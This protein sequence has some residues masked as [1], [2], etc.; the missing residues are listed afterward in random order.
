LTTPKTPGDQ[1]PGSSRG[2]ALAVF[3]PL[4]D[5]L[6]QSTTVELFQSR[7]IAVAP[8]SATVGNPLQPAYFSAAGVVTVTTPKGSG[9]LTLSWE[10]PVFSLF[11]PPVVATSL[12]ARDLLRELTNQLS[13]RVKNR[14][15]NFSLLL[16]IGVPSVLS[17]QALKRQRLRRDTEV[18]YLFRTLRGELVVTLD[19]DVDPSS[20]DF[21]GT[22]KVA[23]EGDFIPF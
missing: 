16:T 3:R 9:S 19:L 15:L 2:A 22:H 13:G 20:L 6:V 12:A 1:A 23:K 7:G 11:S 18:V 5:A 14:L 8:I 17:G 4:L 10:D 21:S